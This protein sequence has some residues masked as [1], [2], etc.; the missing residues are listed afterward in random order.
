MESD[1]PVARSPAH[2]HVT[3][4]GPVADWLRSTEPPRE[5]KRAPA[6]VKPL[7]DRYIGS[8][9]IV[10]WCVGAL[11]LIFVAAGYGSSGVGGAVGGALF[12][13]LL[14]LPFL[15]WSQRRQSRYREHW[16]R[17]TVLDAAVRS[18]GEGVSVDMHGVSHDVW[19]VALHWTASDGLPRVGEF[20]L[21]RSAPAPVVGTAWPLL[22]SPRSNDI[23]MALED[24]MQYQLVASVTR[25]H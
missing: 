6:P 9:R 13:G 2:D 17:G 5:L 19:V 23:A 24:P 8:T 15:A 14:A 21:L 12:G 18:V 16:E 7:L 25:A 1:P 20:R 3:P 10:H 22:E 11:T 4:G